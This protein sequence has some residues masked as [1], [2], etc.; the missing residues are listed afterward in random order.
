MDWAEALPHLPFRL[1][2]TDR[3]GRVL[4]LSGDLP[5]IKIGRSFLKLA[6][7]DEV[8]SLGRAA[9]RAL[10]DGTPRRLAAVTTADKSSVSVKLMP[11]SPDGGK[12]DHLLVIVGEPEASPV[13]RTA[14]PVP[15]RRRGPKV[16]APSAEP[17]FTAPEDSPTAGLNT[18]IEPTPATETPQTAEERAAIPLPPVPTAVELVVVA[19]GGT[20]PLARDLEKVLADRVKTRAWPVARFVDAL[21]KRTAGDTSPEALEGALDPAT[22]VL[23]IGDSPYANAVRENAHRTGPERS[24]SWAIGGQKIRAAAVWPGEHPAGRPGEVIADLQ[25]EM[26]EVVR[27]AMPLRR[28]GRMVPVAPELSQAAAFLEQPAAMDMSGDA[29]SQARHCQLVMSIA[30]FIQEGLEPL[31]GSREA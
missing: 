22:R 19:A 9:K 3:K 20:L 11:F 31:I 21:S 18:I 2:V 7:E 16:P 17:V 26:M 8:L 29:A 1:A 23:F 12:A 10:K 6:D 30:R 28:Q 13:D 14:S 4:L 24:G 5:G 15:A 25:F 27:R